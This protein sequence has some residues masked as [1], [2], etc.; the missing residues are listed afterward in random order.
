[1]RQ[2]RFLLLGGN[3]IKTLFFKT[4][5]LGSSKQYKKNKG[6]RVKEW[7]ETGGRFFQKWW[8]E[9]IPLRSCVTVEQRAL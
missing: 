9:N 5:I 3:V 2:T 8:S 4:I 1:M 6:G 7:R